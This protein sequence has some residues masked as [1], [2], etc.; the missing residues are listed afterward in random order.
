MPMSASR[1]VTAAGTV[2]PPRPTVLKCDMCSA[3]QSGWSSRLVTK[4]GGPPPTD[5]PSLSISSSTLPG[6][7]T[8]HEIDRRALQNGNQERAE[9]ADEVS[10]RRG[11]ELPAAVGRVVRQQLAGLEAERLMAVDDALRLARRARG[12]RD[13][14]R[15]RRIG[16]DRAASGS[17]ASRSSKRCTCSRASARRPRPGRRSGRPRT[18]PAGSSSGRTP[19]R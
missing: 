2:D 16:G 18:G 1:R 3:V 11:R 15:A 4:Y 17:S 19:R 12:E 14:R 9:H 7:H 10:D 13:Q 8:S 6:S 5:S